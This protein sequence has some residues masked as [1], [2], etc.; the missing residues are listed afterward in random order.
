ML[1]ISQ[2]QNAACYLRTT[3]S[4]LRTGSI[5]FG[6]NLR[7]FQQYLISESVVDSFLCF[8]PQV[9][10][11]VFFDL[12]DALSAVLGD[13]V[14][15][16]ASQPK[17]FSCLDLKIGSRSLHYARDQRLMQEYPA[18]RQDKTFARS[19]TAKEDRSHARCLSDAIRC[20]VTS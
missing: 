1:F 16:P 12:F 4:L 2:T 10:V 20:N 14:V 19:S 7:S 17:Y 15:E 9:T 6:F 18:V 11:A 13:D 5:L 3:N 8:E